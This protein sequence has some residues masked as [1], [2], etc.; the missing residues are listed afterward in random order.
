MKNQELEEARIIAN[1]D[2]L[3]EELNLTWLII[4]YRFNTKSDG[5]RVAALTTT[6]W[7]YRQAS[8]EFTLPVTLLL[9]DLELRR[10]CV[11]ELV[12]V[13]VASMEM[14]LPDD[15]LVNKVCELAVENVTQAI[16]GVLP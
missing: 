13:L 3:I 14:Q 10:L 9:T 4:T 8:I 12:H 1:M 16:L 5:D 7:E 11:H 6:D 15:P 2:D